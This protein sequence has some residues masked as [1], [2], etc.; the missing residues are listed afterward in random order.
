MLVLSDMYECVRAHSRDHLQFHFDLKSSLDKRPLYDRKNVE[1]P[2]DRETQE[3]ARKSNT[4]GIFVPV[5]NCVCECFKWGEI[6]SIQSEFLKQSIIFSFFEARHFLVH[7]RDFYLNPPKRCIIHLSP[8]VKVHTHV[9]HS[10]VGHA[11]W[12][13][14]SITD[15][16]NLK[17]IFHFAIGMKWIFCDRLFDQPT[18]YK[19]KKVTKIVITF[20]WN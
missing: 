7:Q 17:Y 8:T 16:K 9:Y 2:F 20:N 13:A 14:I 5:M 4:Y 3:I 18:K 15:N 6:R 12:F 10:A 1:R 19:K 11:L